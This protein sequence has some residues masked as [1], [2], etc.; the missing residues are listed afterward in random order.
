MMGK[1]PRR[2]SL[3]THKILWGRAA[4]RCAFPDCRRE[5]VIDCNAVDDA[6]LVGEECHMVA[7]ELDASRG[8]SPLTS[9]QRDAYE[10]LILLCNTH[11]KIVDDQPN[12]YPVELLQQMKEEQEQWVRDSLQ[13]AVPIWSVP[14][15][16][17][18]FFTGRDDLLDLL[19]DR[20]TTAKATA[21]TQPQA[22]SGLGGIGKTQIAIEYAY[23]YRAAYHAVFWVK[24]SSRETLLLDYVIIAG[25]LSL[26]QKDEQDQN[27][28]VEAVKQWLAT[29]TDW[30]LILDNADDLDMVS[31]FLPTVNRGHLLLTTRTQA[32]G[33]IADPISVEKMN[34]NE[35]ML[36]LLRRSRILP[37]DATLDQVCQADQT[38]IKAIVAEMDG[39]PLALDQAGAYIEQ[40]DCSLAQYL[41]LY[42]Q[43][44]SELLRWRGRLSTEYPYTV[45]TTWSLSFQQVEQKNAASAELLRLCSFLDPDILPVYMFIEGA[46]YLG[47][48][49]QPIAADPF[50]LNEAI[51]VLRQ[52]SLVRRTPDKESLSI[53]RLVQVVLKDS[54]DSTTQ[55]QWAERTVYLVNAILPGER[56]LPIQQYLLHALVCAEHI[57]HYN[58]RFREAARLLDLTAT[59]LHDSSLYG[60]AE[61]FYKRAL[62]IE[63]HAPGLDSEDI[64]A[65]LNNLA[66]LYV[67]QGRFQEAEPLYEHA[68]ALKSIFGADPLEM[69]AALDNL[70][71]L[72]VK[73][74]R[75]QEAGPLLLQA[76][77]IKEHMLGPSHPQTAITLDNLA[78]FYMR[79]GYP[80]E[81][82]SLYT[83]AL[84]I[85]ESALGPD[86]PETAASLNNLAQLYESQERYE[87][88]EPLYKR[89]LT[90]DENV[91]G[92]DHLETAVALNNLAYL[93]V[94]QGRY[95][96]AEPLYKRA[97]ATKERVLGEN[98]PT[99]AATLG[100]LA[101]LYMRQERYQETEPLLQRILA[102]DEI[103]YGCD[104]PEVAIDLETYAMLLRQMERVEEAIT[105]EIRAKAIRDAEHSA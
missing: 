102:I 81:A 64:A 27:K 93:Y 37:V 34:Q 24:A 72:Y 28:V 40:T 29:H 100:N 6:S 33:T 52:F 55:K 16:P 17:N 69:A 19:H 84:N 18:P 76:L 42:L 67:S 7:K 79:L 21:L 65:S 90:I 43:R 30:L 3:K 61:L 53:H 36:L 83:R 97:L 59:Y 91:L 104:H 70:A 46:I 4:S 48:V 103:I 68:L 54:I 41:D 51:D 8:E 58:L 56:W 101:H 62:A 74:E 82:E 99:I 44:R 20:L 38:T 63:S 78:R 77:R 95:E 9:K 105:H 13:G 86:H 49:L 89:A 85:L 80:Q 35:S 15:R 14:Y 98:A 71:Y 32:T 73:Q 12:T 23:N 31:D 22:L 39:L 60:Q 10:N 88:A 47:P 75:Y 92:L 50:K 45:A 11:H 66:Y 25:L 2:I 5:L 94:N 26:P 1:N 96:E 87:E 57:E